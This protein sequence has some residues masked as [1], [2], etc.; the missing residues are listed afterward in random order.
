MRKVLKQMA[1]LMVVG[2]MTVALLAGCGETEKPTNEE[3]K[4]EE[5][6]AEAIADEGL[7]EEKSSGNL[8]IWGGVP[9]ESGPQGVIDK[10]NSENPDYPAEYVRFVNDESGNT[11]L[12]TA[13]LSGEQIDV[14]FTYSPDILNKRAESDMLEDL[15]N[16][17]GEAFITE[18]ILG[19]IESIPLIDD[20][21]FCMPTASETIGI[22][23]NQNMLDE[24]GI[25]IPENWTM[26][27]FMEISEQLTG[28][29]DGKK[30][31]GTTVF[32]EEMLLPIA[33]STLGGDWMYKSDTESNFDHEVV[34]VNSQLKEM[35]DNGTALPYEEVITRKL[36]A[37][38]HPAFL[39]EEIAMMPTAAWMLRYIRDLEN[40]PHDFV[41]TFVPYP[42]IDENTP[43][44]YLGNLNNYI[45]INSKSEHKEKAWE[46]MQY[47]VRECGEFIPK[48]PA[49]SKADIADVTNVVLG[50]DPEKL[51]DVEAYQEVMLNTD[52]KF[53]LTTK[54]DGLAQMTQI[55][56]DETV[57]YLLGELAEDEYY[58]S[59]K[60]KSDEIL[61]K[62]AK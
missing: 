27:D 33:K 61:A 15:S 62:E 47:W 49:W 7:V 44:P 52:M 23:V 55:Y 3:G 10:W 35:I 12:D 51:F 36:A 13:L 40:F 21:I 38:A 30:V 18:E 17:D 29:V 1:S 26:E 20:K 25:T 43:N 39:N 14:F 50:E 19:G 45:S 37:Y 31:Y 60:T 32:Y 28:E 5:T 24:K 9:G 16:F 34:K 6:K 2:T 58:V 48:S 53:Q 42:A 8:V 22:L 56:K 41:T 11:K 57:K 54:T 46:F 4:V 59:M